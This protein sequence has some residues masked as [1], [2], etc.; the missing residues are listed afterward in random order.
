VQQKIEHLQ[1]KGDHGGVVAWTAV[2]HQL[3][4]ISAND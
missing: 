1:R 3:S 2:A 4:R